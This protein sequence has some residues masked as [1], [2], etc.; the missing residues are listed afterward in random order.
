[1][2]NTGKNSYPII[3]HICMAIKFTLVIPPRENNGRRRLFSDPRDFHSSKG[4]ELEDYENFLKKELL[5]KNMKGVNMKLLELNT[6]TNSQNLTE[7]MIND[8]PENK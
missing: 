4:I 8:M 5:P 6:R 3:A 7:K 1:M 2:N